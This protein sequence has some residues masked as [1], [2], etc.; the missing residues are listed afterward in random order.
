L[1]ATILAAFFLMS[2]PALHAQLTVGRWS[3]GG[4]AGL[5]LY[6]NDFNV[7][8]VG[9][10]LELN[11]KYGLSSRFSVGVTAGYE[12]LKSHLVPNDVGLPFDYIKLHAIPL[13]VVAYMNFM[14]GNKLAPYAYAGLGVMFYKRWDG[15]KFIPD[16]FQSSLNIPLGLGVE[17]FYTKDLSFSGALDLHVID[18]S[19]ELYD[20]GGFDS[21]VTLKVGANLYFGKSKADDDDNDGLA[22]GEEEA[23]GTNLLNS[24][25]DN[26]GL[27]DGDEVRVYRSNP[28]KADSD[29]D[30]LGDGDEVL[31]FKTNPVLP[32]SDLDSVSDKDEL[33]GGTNPLSGDSD[34]DGVPDPEEIAGGTNPV[35][36]DTD[37]DGLGDAEEKRVYLTDPLKPDTDGDGLTDGDEV[38]R[39]TNPREPDTDGGGTP[40]GVE[41]SK[42]TD[43]LNIADDQLG[44]AAA[45]SEGTPTI[46]EGIA[47]A[48]GKATFARGSE[49]ALENA[50]IALILNSAEVVEIVGH[51][52]EAATASENEELSRARAEAVVAWMIDRGIPPE[53]LRAVGRGSKDPMSREKGDPANRRIEM[54]VGKK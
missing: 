10:G 11:G 17:Y 29:N 30:G 8:K 32:D 46:L 24:D 15:V 5:N 53:R 27:R 23:L 49:T 19:T 12:E 18:E 4:S 26:D 20:A 35:A 47:F 13:A 14:P 37:G 54:R 50:F 21:Y 48:P 42:A 6:L 16:G 51:T 31:Q 3:A 7:R 2:A 43:P 33:D 40:D 52:D 1:L 41:V 36:S 28:L 45:L 38:I 44:A 39:A 25:S 34:T 22:N 9:P